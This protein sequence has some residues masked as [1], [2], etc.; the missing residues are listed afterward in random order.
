MLDNKS[1]QI[2]SVVSLFHKS[3]YSDGAGNC[4]EVAKVTFDVIVAGKVAATFHM[5][6]VRDSK[7]PNLPAQWYTTAE[8]A[9]FTRGVKDGE[10]D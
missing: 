4:V 7:N 3:S 9:A 1:A 10:F 2:S 6:V 8:W 5:Y